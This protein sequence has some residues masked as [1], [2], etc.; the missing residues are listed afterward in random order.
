MFTLEEIQETVNS[1][2]HNSPSGIMCI[3]VALNEKWGI[4]LYMS[5]RYRDD[6]FKRQSLAASL[7]LAPEVG[8]SIDL[9]VGKWKYGFITE[10]VE[11]VT[12]REK[13]ANMCVL[14]WAWPWSKE[15]WEKIEPTIDRLQKEIG[16]YFA[17]YH[18]ENWGY[19]KDG[20]LIP[21]DFGD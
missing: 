17:D 6:S 10:I 3:F 13:P 14:V 4:K 16:W 8:E 7:G 21:I 20:H 15:N 19:H 5:K 1:K 9:G 18:G 12:D 2:L 11:L